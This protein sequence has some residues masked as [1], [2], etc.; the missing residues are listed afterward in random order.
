[1]KNTVLF[2]S[3][4]EKHQNKVKNIIDENSLQLVQMDKD[5]LMKN[6]YVLNARLLIV[7][8]DSYNMQT[9]NVIQSA[10][11]LEYIPVIFFYE[12]DEGFSNSCLVSDGICV[13]VDKLDYCLSDLINQGI[14]FKTNY[15]IMKESYEA[16][17][18][19]NSEIK[20]I[21]DDFLLRE[22]VYDIN[23]VERLLNTVFSDNEIISN[24]PAQIW[25]LFEEINTA[26]LFV[27]KEQGG[28][29]IVETIKFS[30]FGK[31]D[32]DFRTPNGFHKNLDIKEYSDIESGIKL[33]PDMIENLLPEMKNFSGFSIDDLT[34]MGFNYPKSVSHFDSAVLKA[35]AI[36]VD[37]IDGVKKNMK[38]VEESFIYT[39]N[40][41]ARAAEVNDDSTGYHIKRVNFFSKVLANEM[42]CNSRFVKEIFNSA[43]MHDVGKIYVDKSVLTKPG[44]LT[45]EEFDHMK[46]HT[47]HGEKI[48]GNSEHLKMASEIARNHHEK[49]DGSGY[50]DGR[51]G[52]QIPLSARIVA[53]ADIYD[54][55]RSPRCYKPAFSHEKTLDIIINGDGRVEP[56]HFDPNVLKV[57]KRV[58][59]E[60]KVLYDK[61]Q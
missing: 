1:M 19:L 37:L 40:A 56:T 50:P 33:F 5:D 29:E 21:I 53:L 46:L 42:G 32:F 14:G 59:N 2:M 55:L 23:M 26:V 25:V 6:L 10:L 54:A 11:N 36:N 18:L 4:S 44:K 48:I 39:M 9:L 28:M 34:L 27:K 24:Y 15:N 16:I 52:I 61:F 41:L 20:G 51:K 35:I 43:Q 60:F 8:L 38:R 3:T 13:H 31:F 22:D 12:N 45:E 49:Y 17:D 47:V 57:F 58:H 7:D 30:E